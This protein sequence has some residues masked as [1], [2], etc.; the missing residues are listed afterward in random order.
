MR[1]FI[2]ISTKTGAALCLVFAVLVLA[3]PKA[4]AQDTTVQ[5]ETKTILD[6]LGAAGVV[7]IA[8]A[9]ASVLCAILALRTVRKPSPWPHWVPLVAGLGEVAF[10]LGIITG[11]VRLY[12]GLRTTADLRAATTFTD[13]AGPVSEA[14]AA[15]ILGASA[16]LV[17]LLFS[18]LVR[19][20]E[21]PLAPS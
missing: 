5:V 16:S 12:W 8:L 18:G 14:L 2:S 15:V 6:N 17:A 10:L 4:V 7:I 19:L 20:R 3:S 11:F 13:A 1:A 9:L 21:R